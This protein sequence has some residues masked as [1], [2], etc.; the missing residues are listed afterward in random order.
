MLLPISLSARKP[1]FN[2]LKH[3]IDTNQLVD[4]LIATRKL[5]P[6]SY[7]NAVGS[8]WPKSCRRSPLS[9]H[10]TTLP[11]R[12]PPSDLFQPRACHLNFG[13]A[14]AGTAFGNFHPPRTSRDQT[15]NPVHTWVFSSNDYYSWYVPLETSGSD[16]LLVTA[17]KVEKLIPIPPDF[18]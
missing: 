15:P 13:T 14:R 10:A 4:R 5:S 12:R 6:P 17:K 11:T 18:H 3:Q 9:F 8:G 16:T 1:H 7:S 2:E